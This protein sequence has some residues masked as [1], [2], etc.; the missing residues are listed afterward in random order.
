V[1]GRTHAPF[2]LAKAGRTVR[3]FRGGRQLDLLAYPA[4]GACKG[5]PSLDR[6]IEWLSP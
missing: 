1:Q 3:L 6:S 4:L 5:W 2:K